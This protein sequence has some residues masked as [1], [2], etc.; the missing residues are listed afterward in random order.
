MT[1]TIYFNVPIQLLRGVLTGEK[2]VN[3]FTQSV[4]RYSL[5]RHAIHLPYSEDGEFG[6]ENDISTQLKA[7]ANFLN[8]KMGD[9]NHII[10]EG[11]TMA[12]QYDNK[13]AYCGLNTD[14]L[15]NYDKNPKTERQIA[16]LC[17]F[18]ATKSI[19]GKADYKR[20]N[21]GLIIARMFGYSTVADFEKDAPV[22]TAKN[23]SKETRA[24]RKLAEER[25][26]KYQKRHH[27]DKILKD[28][29]LSW[30][31]KH[32]SDHIR[33]MYISY[34]SNLKTLAE[35]C[36]K[37]KRSFKEKGLKEAKQQARE[38]AKRMAS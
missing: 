14:I 32:Y 4:V 36:E 37:S 33:G 8:V 24:V 19:L 15:W 28:L 21:K 35:V 29:E 34:K 6:E 16:Q 22:L 25:R 26:Q 17:A 2:T 1:D 11:G 10:R 27:I 7:A 5:Y 23:I 30:G 31:L 20:T 9:I 3:E 13:V 12:E 38:A 18:C